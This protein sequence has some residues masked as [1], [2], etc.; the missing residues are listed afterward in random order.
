VSI[1]HTLLSFSY[2][3]E[4]FASGRRQD[5]VPWKQIK[6]HTASFIDPIY[7]PEVT[8]D[9]TDRVALIEDPSDMKKEQIIRLLE[10]W[11]RAVPG[12]DLFRFSHVLVNSKSAEMTAA[13]YTD[14]LG[15]QSLPQN[16]VREAINEPGVGDW[17]QEYRNSN[18]A[19]EDN[20]QFSLDANGGDVNMSAPEEERDQLNQRA[21]PDPDTV[22]DQLPPAPAPKR[23]SK[24]K[25]K[26]KAAANSGAPTGPGP[27][28]ATTSTS[29]TAQSKDIPTETALS[30][31]QDKNI[32]P[33]QTTAGVPSVP[34]PRPKPRPKNPKA[35][36]STS[37]DTGGE[38][39][40]RQPQHGELEELLGRSHR[41][42]KKRK[43]DACLTQQF[44]DAEKKA[45]KDAEKKAQKKQRKRDP[46]EAGRE[47]KRQRTV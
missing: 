39:V 13:L 11:R 21:S 3:S 30:D 27:K 43:L 34:C 7:L 25:P 5:K 37:A 4:G 12:R 29:A 38:N 40:P 47:A 31:T 19:P 15:P 24:A 22:N 26:G 35:T 9:S 45:Q 41:V 8:L 28:E 32:Q 33:P 2:V 44:K 10:H 14:S 6:D 1:N 16:E 18:P 23:K 46:V 42:S 17:E 36:D 20:D